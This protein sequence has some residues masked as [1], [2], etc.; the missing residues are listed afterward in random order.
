MFF[1]FLF[2]FHWK[3]DNL[4]LGIFSISYVVMGTWCTNKVK[5]G[6]LQQGRIHFLPALE[7][8]LFHQVVEEYENE[9][10]NIE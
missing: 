10:M 1:L 3:F 7:G 4:I 5:G 9:K 8:E 6:L 2:L